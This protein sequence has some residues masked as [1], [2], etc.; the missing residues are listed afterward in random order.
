VT[1]GVSFHFDRPNALAPQSMLLAVPH[2][3][4]D[5][6]ADWRL[7]DL[8]DIV[9]DTAELTRVRLVDPD[10]LRNLDRLLPAL[11]VPQDPD[12]P[13]YIREVETPNAWQVARHVLTLG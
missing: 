13:A 1:T 5:T 12:R 2:A 4:S 10:A 11:Y 6:A 7:A 8:A 9:R 3:W